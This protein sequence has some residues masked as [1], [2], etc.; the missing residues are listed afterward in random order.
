L[1]ETTFK[2]WAILELMGHRRLG[3][4]IQ[5][6]TIGGTSFVRVDIPGA[7]GQ[8]VATQFYSPQSVYCI[9]PVS[10]EVARAVAAASE[11]APVHRWE[12]PQLREAD[13]S[14]E[15]VHDQGYRYLDRADDV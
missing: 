3:G 12:L 13:E 6:A 15:P 2:E 7:D 4:Y 10:E 8:T 5:E 14:A 1:E 11:V 9:T